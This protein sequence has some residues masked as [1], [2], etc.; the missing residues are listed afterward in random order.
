VIHNYPV[1]QGLESERF[2]FTGLRE[3]IQMFRIDFGFTIP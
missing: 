2:M 3:V 1:A